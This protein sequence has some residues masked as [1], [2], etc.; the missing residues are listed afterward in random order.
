MNLVTVVS[1][2]VVCINFRAEYHEWVSWSGNVASLA[3]LRLPNMRYRGSSYF[4]SFLSGVGL[5]MN[6]RGHRGQFILISLQKALFSI[7][8]RAVSGLAEPRCV[9]RR[10]SLYYSATPSPLNKYRLM[11]P[12]GSGIFLVI[13]Q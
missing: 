2:F 8:L 3:F 11:S 13:V 10:S 9:L 5:G 7:Q 4:C 6:Q 1:F 12:Q